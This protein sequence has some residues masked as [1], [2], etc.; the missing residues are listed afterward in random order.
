MSGAR[1]SQLTQGKSMVFLR[2]SDDSLPNVITCNSLVESAGSFPLLL[3]HVFSDVPDWKSAFV[4]LGTRFEATS[5]M[6][7]L[8]HVFESMIFSSIE[9]DYGR[10]MNFPVF[11]GPCFS[12]RLQEVSG[13]ICDRLWN[14][15][16]MRKS[17]QRLPS[18]LLR[19]KTSVA[20][21]T[22]PSC[23]LD[24]GGQRVDVRKFACS[25]KWRIHPDLQAW[26]S[27]LGQM[28]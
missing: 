25:G 20:S 1:L 28:N 5:S 4:H 15:E 13:G 2:L 26:A 23:M 16:L 11:L 10:P 9:P 22:K 19:P 21:S 24:P 17:L 6:H 27:F 12:T 14:Q 18:V 7:D 8:H 3:C